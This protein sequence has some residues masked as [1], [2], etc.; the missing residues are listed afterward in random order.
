MNINELLTNTEFVH[1]YAALSGQNLDW[2]SNVIQPLLLH[3]N[4]NPQAPIYSYPL[5]H[6]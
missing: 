5:N 4:N 3:H 2:Y 6:L 1:K